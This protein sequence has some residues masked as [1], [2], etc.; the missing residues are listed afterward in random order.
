MFICPNCN[1][2]CK[3]KGDWSRHI[4]TKKHLKLEQDNTDLKKIIIKQQ[5]QIDLQQ[6]QINELIPKIK[7]MTTN[8]FNLNIFLQ[9]KCKDAMNWNEFINSLQIQETND[10]QSISQLICNELYNLGM[11]KRPIHC[12]DIKRKKMCIKN[13]NVWE[14]DDNKVM[15]TL[16]ES[17]LT[18]QHAYLKQWETIHPN[19]YDNENE[20][21]IYTRIINSLTVDKDTITK[22]ICISKLEM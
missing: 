5:E 17:A 2:T 21:D 15:D 16:T 11:Y 13:K 19:W 18:L 14:H 6:K 12:L 3:K 7:N 22:N 9:D 1:F 8:K 10:N 4:A 20:T